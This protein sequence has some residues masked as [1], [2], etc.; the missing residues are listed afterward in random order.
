M[1]Q[2][3]YKLVIELQNTEFKPFSVLSEQNFLAPHIS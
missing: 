2:L 3:Y 1:H